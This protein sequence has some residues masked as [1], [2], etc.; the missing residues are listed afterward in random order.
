MEWSWIWWKCLDSVGFTRF[1][2]LENLH[3]FL[4]SSISGM[5]SGHWTSG[6]TSRR[7][8]LVVQLPQLIYESS[9]VPVA[10]IFVTFFLLW[11]FMS[12]PADYL[13]SLSYSHCS[14]IVLFRGV[15]NL[16][17]ELFILITLHSSCLIFLSCV[18]GR[19][20]ASPTVKMLLYTF[21]R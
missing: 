21:R 5:F 3:L 1:F 11:Y 14:L 6:P 2:R 9:F 4:N 8:D 18:G 19:Y 20:S 15:S 10:F 13:M 7:R 16:Q 12:S 17:G